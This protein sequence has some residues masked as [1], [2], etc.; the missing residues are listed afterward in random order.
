M[1]KLI[2]AIAAMLLL[3]SCKTSQ[4][5]LLRSNEDKTLYDVVKQLNKHGDDTIAIAALP[6]VY[7]QVQQ[8]HLDKIEA[9][10]T[11]TDISRWEKILSEYYILQSMYD[12]VEGSDA[13]TRL[14]KAVS[15]QNQI[16][17]VKQGAA[18]AYYQTGISYLNQQ[19]REDAKKAYNSFKKT[20]N[21]V[22]NYKDSKAQMDIA[23]EA[24]IVNVLIN[25][26]QDNS[27]FINTNWQGNAYSNN[28]FAQKLSTELGGN[29]ASRYPAKF[30]TERDLR[31]NDDVQPD[32]ITDLTVREMDIPRPTVYNY[33]RNL[34]KKIETGKDTA[35]KVTY[36]TVY[37]TL[38]IQKQSF[39]AR[40]TM[41]VNITAA[42]TRKNIFYDNYS[43]S[44]YWQQE[45]ASYSGDSRALSSNDWALVNNRYNMPRKEEIMNELYQGIY[46]QVKSNISSLVSW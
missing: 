13:A 12:A 16:N 15:Y 27:V 43:N 42:D 38:N 14:I 5:Y 10:N 22:S 29:Y 6:E 35:G 25:Q 7:R 18:E 34:S 30:Y 11:Y 1:K 46:S 3:A 41:D 28:N 40:A 19:T 37:A 23:Y 2:P 24:G 36:Q 4:D 20:G 9:Y 26:V 8:K 31:Y 45:V 21:W 32:W 39:N 44:Y 17:A 33:S